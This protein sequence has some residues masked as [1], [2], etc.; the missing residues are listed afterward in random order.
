M[1]ALGY[2]FPKDSPLMKKI[3]GGS[4]EEIVFSSLEDILGESVTVEWNK[5]VERGFRL[6]DACYVSAMENLHDHY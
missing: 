4:E 1:E 5:S 2:K 3:E 6:R